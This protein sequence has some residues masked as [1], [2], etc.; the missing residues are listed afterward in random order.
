MTASTSG[1]RR[2]ADLSVSQVVDIR[3]L[4][5]R[6]SKAEYWIHGAVARL[7]D[8]AVVEQAAS[9]DTH[10]SHG[11]DLRVEVWCALRECDPHFD[12]DNHNIV[13]TLDGRTVMEADAVNH[14]NTGDDRHDQTSRSITGMRVC[15][16]FRALYQQGAQRNWDVLVRIGE[17]YVEVSY[18]HRLMAHRGASCHQ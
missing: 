14:F 7:R 4:D 17:I 1:H 5:N 10:A 3:M 6:L 8:E 2:L 13:A 11:V 16:L 15:H 18:G 12:R 9:V